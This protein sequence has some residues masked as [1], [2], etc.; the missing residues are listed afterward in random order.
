MTLGRKLSGSALWG[1]FVG[2]SCLVLAQ[3][4][5][6]SQSNESG[7]VSNPHFSIGP[8]YVNIPEK[9]F[10]LVRKGPS[11]GAIRLTH[12]ERD[13]RGDGKANYES[14]FQGDGS[15]SFVA[16][17][18]VKRTGEIDIKPMKGVHAFA[19]QPGQNKLWVGKWWFGCLSPS[20][21]NMSSHFSEKD[22]GYEFAPTSAKDLKDVNAAD[23][24]LH[25]YRFDPDKR[26]TVPVSELP[27]SK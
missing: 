8:R 17:N 10:L 2:L 4:Q 23:P 1:V 25:W 15:G 22:E 27:A 21:M 26:I 11:V 12:I 20:T 5:A 24:R 3:S 6:V 16:P 13:A 14:Y 7:E 19:W 9:L 18:V